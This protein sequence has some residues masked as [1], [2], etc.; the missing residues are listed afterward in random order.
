V[1]GNG[2]IVIAQLA[3]WEV[4]RP[5]G[6]A[7]GHAQQS[8]NGVRFGGLLRSARNDTTRRHSIGFPVNLNVV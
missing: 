7:Q 8:P 6:Q 1:P 2:K 4:K 5:S 3:L